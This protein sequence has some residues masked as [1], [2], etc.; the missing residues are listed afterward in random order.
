M[1]NDSNPIRRVLTEEKKD[2]T[3]KILFIA[4]LKKR[5]NKNVSIENIICKT[6]KKT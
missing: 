4:F 3:V 1:I 2:L 5:K 6:K